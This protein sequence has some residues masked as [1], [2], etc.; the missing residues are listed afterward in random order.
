[1]G[2]QRVGHDWA[3]ELNGWNFLDRLLKFIWLCQLLLQHTG[4]S[5]LLL[6]LSSFQSCLTLCDPIDGSQGSNPG[7]FT[8]CAEWRTH[9]HSGPPGKSL[10]YEFE[11]TVRNKQMRVSEWAQNGRSL[12]LL[13]TS[14]FLFVIYLKA[15]LM[16]WECYDPS[17][18]FGFYKSGW[19][20][21]WCYCHSDVTDTC[22]R[23]L[24]LWQIL[25]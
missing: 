16:R 21:V 22:V 15:V 19:V 1:M 7:P 6:L 13:S 5:S 20:H 8:G 11:A 12:N 10:K 17:L 3:T 9:L 2:L 23:K 4:S 25:F 18:L 24:F 14:V